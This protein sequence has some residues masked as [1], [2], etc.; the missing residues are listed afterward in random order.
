MN[1]TEIQE[2]LSHPVEYHLALPERTQTTQIKPIAETSRLQEQYKGLQRH[3]PGQRGRTK[4]SHASLRR[5]GMLEDQQGWM[6]VLY[7]LMII[8]DRI[9]AAFSFTKELLFIE[10]KYDS[11]A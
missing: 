1:T 11:P 8:P 3:L 10:S 4:R 9:N 6:A 7:H 5:P 2:G